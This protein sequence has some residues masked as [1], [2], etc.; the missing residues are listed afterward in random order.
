MGPAPP[1]RREPTT[2]RLLLERVPAI[3]YTA[4]AGA[5]GRWHYVSPQI[6]A[7]LGFHPGGM[8]RRPEA[9]GRPAAPR[10]RA[11]RARQEQAF[12]DG[13]AALSSPIEYRLLHRD[14]HVV[15]VRDD[16]LLR[17]AP[18]VSSAGTA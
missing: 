16:A 3:L 11:A 15:W 12:A 8:V 13:T 4:D 17:R 5:D 14:G 9:V 18:T 1:S 7:I 10:R 2:Q 6:E